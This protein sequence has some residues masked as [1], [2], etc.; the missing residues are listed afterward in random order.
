[1]RIILNRC[2]RCFLGLI[3]AACL[4]PLLAG[5]A[6]SPASDGATSV[7]ATTTQLADLAGNVAGD[8]AEVTGILAPSSDPHE[9]EPRPSDAT[10]L[11]AADLV[12]ASGG[13]VDSWLGQIVEA[14][15]SEAPVVEMIDRVQTLPAADGEGADPHWW[16]DPRN[17]IRAVREIERRL[18]EADP[19]GRRAYA[20]NAT[21]Y[22]R[23]LRRLDAQVA[24]CLDRVPARE[25]LLVT[26]HDSLGPY[27]ARYGIEIVG[28]A[29]PAL[30]TQAQASAGETADLIELIRTTG[31]KTVFPEAGVSPE[32]E[33]AIASSADAALGGEL[34][35]DSLGSA[36]SEGATYVDAVAANTESLVAG[37]TAGAQSCAIDLGS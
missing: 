11:A 9:Y 8:R 15:G 25:R 30:S 33:E 2:I 20:A 3:V 37:F 27:A 6:P 21:A 13:E 24:A 19:A 1:M 34:W 32:L 36:D 29:I 12:L 31:V 5:C 22:V 7:V 17:A 16:Q 28:A 14:S 4:A 23:K 18:S 35:A 26:S 10:A